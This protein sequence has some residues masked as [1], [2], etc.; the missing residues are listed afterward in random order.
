M[1]EIQVNS[2]QRI[3]AGGVLDKWHYRAAVIVF[4]SFI[5]I[6]DILSVRDGAID[7]T[8]GST[9]IVFWLNF[10]CDYMENFILN[11]G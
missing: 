4:V 10:S 2:L 7:C 8:S 11:F 1:E 6:T 3:L 5:W 9:V